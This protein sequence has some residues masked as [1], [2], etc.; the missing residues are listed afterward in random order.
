MKY[1]LLKNRRLYKL[2]FQFELKK[3]QLKFVLLNQYLPGYIR[4]HAFNKLNVMKPYSSLTYVRNRCFI[5]NKSRSVFN[6]F[7]ISRIKLRNLISNNYLN[8][9]KKSSW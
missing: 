3:L 4:Q 1:L 9:I 6:Y 2:F 8:G 5:T 7:R